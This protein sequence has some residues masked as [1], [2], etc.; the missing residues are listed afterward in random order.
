MNAVSPQALQ[1]PATILCLCPE[2]GWKEFFFSSLVRGHF[3]ITEL[4]GDLKG[5]FK[6]GMLTAYSCIFY[7]RI[8]DITCK[9]FGNIPQA[10]IYIPS[11]TL[12]QHLNRTSGQILHEAGQLILQ[13]NPLGG[14]PETHTLHSTG[15]H[16]IFSDCTHNSNNTK[17]RS[18]K[19]QIKF[20]TVQKWD[21]SVIISKCLKK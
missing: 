20:K 12:D 18:Q 11:R 19:F 13:C 16:N 1:S 8:P 15:K 9:T 7:L 5:D 6:S 21:K 4:Q 3:F 14:K 2:L 17:A 10:I